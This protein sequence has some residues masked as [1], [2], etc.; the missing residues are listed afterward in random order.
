M[1][2]VARA[3][4]EGTR[5]E[6]LGESQAEHHQAGIESQAAAR[7][8]AAAAHARERGDHETAKKLSFVARSYGEQAKQRRWDASVKAFSQLNSVSEGSE[9]LDLHSLGVSEAL[10]AV[11]WTLANSEGPR[12]LTIV[13]GKG[14]HSK[15][16]KSRIAPAVLSLLKSRNL[17]HSAVQQG[18]IVVQVPIGG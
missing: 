13:V 12:T 11:M 3:R 7:L 18:Q 1:H 4:Y 15:A 17:A 6:L 9:V 5:G 2:E 14:L 8:H 16:G 10:E